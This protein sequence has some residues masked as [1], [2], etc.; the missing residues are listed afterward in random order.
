MGAIPTIVIAGTGDD[1]LWSG[2]GFEF[3]KELGQ[4]GRVVNDK[5]ASESDEIGC[6]FFDG[7]NELG[8]KLVVSSR[9]VVQV[10]ELGYFEAVESFGPSG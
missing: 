7:G 8:E 3:A 4:G 5:V 1:S 9:T 2:E 10:G 6:F